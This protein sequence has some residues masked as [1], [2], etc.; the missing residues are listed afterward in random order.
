MTIDRGRSRRPVGGHL[1]QLGSERP[2]CCRAGL[3]RVATEGATAWADRRPRPG[4]RRTRRLWHR[5]AAACHHMAVKFLAAAVAF[6]VRPVALSQPDAPHRRAAA[7]P[8][9][10]RFANTFGDHMVLQAG[11]FVSVWGHGPAPGS[12]VSVVSSANPSAVTTTTT[13]NNTWHV[14]LPVVAAGSMAH[15]VTATS[16]GKSAALRDVLFGDVWVCSGQVRHTGISRAAVC[17]LCWATAVSV[18]HHARLLLCAACAVQH[19]VH[20]G[21]ALQWRSICSGRVLQSHS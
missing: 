15:T 21:P 4:Y 13:A 8:P 1:S 12:L 14:R 18:S 7:G 10:L 11:P 6:L 16:G 19:A 5:A 9:E 20:D 2:P 17:C 3:E